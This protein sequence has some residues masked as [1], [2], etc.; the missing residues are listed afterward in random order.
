M[1][2][3]MLKT[4]VEYPNK[5]EEKGIILRMGAVGRRPQVS[6]VTSPER[7]LAARELLNEIYVDEKVLTYV[8]DLVFATRRP[9]EHGLK[10]LKHLILYGASPRASLAL[11]QAARAKA[12][13]EGRG[14]VTP[15]DIKSVGM[16]V[17]RHRVI[18]TYE[19]EAEELTSE[20]VIQQLFDTV[21]VP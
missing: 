11:T 13:L 14:Y 8:V 12:F 21:P 7:V 18:T 9:E 20:H 6:R 10:E 1:D 17:L 16:D 5:E 3:F 15:Q 19:A 4:V 2:R